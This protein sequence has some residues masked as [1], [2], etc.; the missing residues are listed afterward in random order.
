MRKLYEFLVESLSKYN[1]KEEILDYL[2]KIKAYDILNY[3]YDQTK[4]PTPPDNFKFIFKKSETAKNQLCPIESKI[5]HNEFVAIA[6]KYGLKIVKLFVS[7]LLALQP[8]S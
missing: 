5:S 1:T 2:E 4:S 8:D 7:P 3:I 6:E